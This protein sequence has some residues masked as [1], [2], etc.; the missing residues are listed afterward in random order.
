M[1]DV[2]TVRKYIATD[3]E[4]VK[5]NVPTCMTYPQLIRLTIPANLDR[6]TGSFEYNRKTKKT[7]FQIHVPLSETREDVHQFKKAILSAYKKSLDEEEHARCL[8][9]LD[10]IQKHNYNYHRLTNLLKKL[11]ED[12]S[13][14]FFHLIL[15]GYVQKFSVREFIDMMSLLLF[16]MPDTSPSASVIVLHTSVLTKALQ[17]LANTLN[18]K[19]DLAEPINAYFTDFVINGNLDSNRVADIKAMGNWL[20]LLKE[21]VDRVAPKDD[22]ILVLLKQVEFQYQSA[23]SAKCMTEKK[24]TV[25]APKGPTLNWY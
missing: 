1:F 17:T 11:P 18:L 5:I 6:Y 14:L 3:Q 10:H 19:V 24:H 15:T 13:I 16:R 7:E 2:D 4:I 23:C 21:D 22:R 25:R 8:M 9:Q 12:N 20:Y